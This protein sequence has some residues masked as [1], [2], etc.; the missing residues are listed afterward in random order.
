MSI[1]TIKNENIEVKVN[2]YGG[3]LDSVKVLQTG[4]QLLWQ[5]D[6]DIWADKDIVVFPMIGRLCDKMYTVDG[7]C[8]S[9]DIHGLCLYSKFEVDHTSECSVVLKL[10]FSKASLSKYPFKFV[11]SLTYSL[12]GNKLSTKICVCN[13]GEKDMPFML[14][15]HPGY[16]VDFD[17]ENHLIF[18]Q[19]QVVQRVEMDKSNVFVKG[20]YQPT[21]VSK[22]KIDKA[23]FAMDAVLLENVTGGVTL[24]KA[25]GTSIHFEL[26]NPPIFAF[27]SHRD[28]GNYIAIEPWW[29]LPDN[30]VPEREFAKKEK[31]NIL[32]PNQTFEYEFN[33][34]Y[35]Y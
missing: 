9:M 30:T 20:R 35:L 11:L 16:I 17:A 23:L 29:G 28:K 26:N 18:D 8:H 14:G 2:T 19:K 3:G 27:W 7:E 34:T 10:A 31:V 24:Q 1:I 15:A 13:Q 4:E 33:T 22:I 12:D 5:S 25:N 32:A 21:E 6:A